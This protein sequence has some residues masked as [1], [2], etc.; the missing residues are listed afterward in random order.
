MI[1]QFVP[2]REFMSTGG[3]AD[4]GR[5]Q[6]RL[7]KEVLYEIPE[8]FVGY[9]KKNGVRPKPPV[10]HQTSVSEATAPPRQAVT[11]QVSS[12]YDQSSQAH[13]TSPQSLS[14][15]S[16]SNYTGPSYQGGGYSRI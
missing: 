15:T 13:P 12:P 7:A 10:Q 6:A 1:L 9:M 5:S 3:A 11:A 2:F 16:G 4:M 8:Q 14:F